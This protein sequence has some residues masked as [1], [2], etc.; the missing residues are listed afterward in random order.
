MA[1]MKKLNGYEVCD[2]SLR[3]QINGVTTGGTGAAYT[4]TVNGITSLANGA[5]FTMIPHTTATTASPTLNVNGQGAVTIMRQS[6]Y[7]AEPVGSYV[8]TMLIQ[9]VPVRMTYYQNGSTKYWII[10][11]AVPFVGSSVMGMLPIENG[12]TGAGTAA[13]ALNN[14]GITWGTA[15]APSTGTPNTIYIQI[16]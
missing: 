12:G 11:N 13:T 6:T 8:N 7:S 5:S 15:A 1:L 9:G 2:D 3:I 10:D 4:A 16:N 14:L